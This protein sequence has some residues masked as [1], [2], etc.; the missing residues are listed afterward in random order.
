[1]EGLAIFVSLIIIAFGILQIVLFFKIWGMTNNI[2]RIWK[3]IDHEKN[4]SIAG[5]SYIQGNIDETEKLLNE[6]FLKDVVNL[7]ENTNDWEEWDKGYNLLES[8]YT[9]AFKK[10]ERPAPDF[11]KYRNPKIYLV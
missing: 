3:K 11:K 9:K 1:M 8:K 5:L 10:I 6:A 7:S 4:F 2:K